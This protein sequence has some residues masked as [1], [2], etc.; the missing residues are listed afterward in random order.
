MSRRISSNCF[1]EDVRNLLQS[2]AHSIRKNDGMIS[3]VGASSPLA[4]A[5]LDR[6]VQDAYMIN[7]QSIDSSKDVSMLE[8][9]GLD[10]SL[11][12]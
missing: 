1:T 6:I 7:I 2:F 10:K 3:L 8:V 4:D 11:R 9:Y 5:I 12:E